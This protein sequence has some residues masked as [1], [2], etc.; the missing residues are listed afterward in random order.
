[1]A[2][3]LQTAPA[4]SRTATRGPSWRTAARTAAGNGTLAVADQAVVSGMSFLTT[5]AVGRL[6]GV[7][8]LGIYS[9]GLTA[10]VFC[11]NAQ[12]ALLFSPYTVYGNRLTGSARCV[13][14][15]STLVHATFLAAAAA[16][17]LAAGGWWCVH[18]AGRA[19]FAPVAWVL[20]GALPWVLLREFGRRY[21]FAHSRMA[22]AFGLD[23]AVM[24]VQAAVLSALAGVGKLTAVGGHAALGVAC[25]AAGGCWLL[26]ARA[27]FCVRAGDVAPALARNWALGK[28]VAASQLTGS[29]Q[30]YAVYWLLAALRGTAATGGYS[31]CMTLILLSNPLILGLGNVLVARTAK[32]CAAGGPA[33]VRHLVLRTSLG[34]AALLAAFAALVVPFGG[35]LLEALYGSR[36]GDF[37]TTI[38][39]LAL[40]LVVNASGLS[41]IYGLRSLERP[42]VNWWASLASLAATLA[43]AGSLIGPWGVPGA[44]AG[45]LIGNT[46]GMAVRW[47][48]FLR[49][50]RGRQ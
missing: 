31:A 22:T 37:A 30:G 3:E 7:E 49:L 36:Y 2:T 46:T 15:G 16:S 23:T 48:A 25:A 24:V 28:W 19:V 14:A 5:V 12:E 9:L 6:A 4:P 18:S 40:D 34:C 38:G 44:A 43:V 11:V 13:Y 21:A 33:E 39:L 1:M 26:R 35:V 41:V 10:V 8:E 42:Q 45:F 17:A 20:A 29:A 27:Q 50:T 32:A 47:V